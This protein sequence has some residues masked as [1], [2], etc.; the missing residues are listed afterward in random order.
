ML[1]A[2]LNRMLA[3]SLER[4]P[5]AR[6]LCTVLEGR[7]L[8]LEI[9][10][11]PASFWIS[12]AG[13][14][15]TVALASTAAR[16]GTAARDAE[17]AG[18]A[19]AADVTADVTV[20]GSPFALFAMATGDASEAVTRGGASV[21]GDE[22]LAQ[23]FQ[24]LARLLRPDLEHAL[25]GVIGRMPAHFAARAA[26]MLGSWGRA[27]VES[28][29]RDTADYLGHESRDLVPRAEAENFLGGVEALRSR[30]AAAEA[31]AVQL[32]ERLAGLAPLAPPI[33]P[34]PRGRA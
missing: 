31:R 15:L 9:T 24:E 21:G 34:T 1:T 6:E 29:A 30:L 11:L 19:I 18:D 10:G 26:A 14:S 2:Q 17:T 25:G 32:D 7:R 12:A 22:M 13:G 33:A 4:S 20:S 3:G 16:A 23:Q 8:M 5:R 28:V 27:A